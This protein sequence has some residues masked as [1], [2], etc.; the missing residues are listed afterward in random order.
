M[1]RLLLSLG[2]FFLLIGLGFFVRS[3]ILISRQKAG[4]QINCQPQATI[5]LDGRH[6]GQT[7]FENTNLKPG[8][9]LLKLVPEASGLA[10]WEQKIKLTRGIKTI[11]N[12]KLAETQEFA[13]GEILTLES[14]A[15]PKL[16]ALAIIS[17]PSEALVKIDGVTRGFTPISIE[18]ITEGNHRI[19]LTLPGYLEKEVQIKTLLGKK[20]IIDIKMAKEKLLVEEA[21][22][23]AEKEEALEV[24]YVEIKETPTGWLRVRMG[25]SLSATEAAKINPG[26]KYPLLDEEGGWLKIRYQDNQEGWISGRYATKF[27]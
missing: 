5:F 24:P 16:I 25:P 19:N 12:Q 6:L 14:L 13:S 9:Y 18:D 1:K 27:E 22:P 23:S 3:R 11:I 20:L 7:P 8:E 17:S 10:S 2:F 21:T 4:L 26:E 15:N